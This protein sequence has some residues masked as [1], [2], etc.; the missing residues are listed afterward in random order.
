MRHFG[1]LVAISRRSTHPALGLGLF[2][3]A[4]ALSSALGQTAAPYVLPYTM[5]TYVGAHASYT[6]GQACGAAI[7]LDLDGDGCVAS[8]ASVSTDPHDVRVDPFGFLYYADN[9]NSVGVIHRVNPYSGLFTSYF[10]N[11]IGNSKICATADATT[12]T[13]KSGTGCISSDGV[14][15]SGPVNLL[16]T[17]SGLANG[18]FYAVNTGAIRG[19]GIDP[20]GNLF[21]ANYGQDLIEVIAA[22]GHKVSLVGGQYHTTGTTNGAAYTQNLT[23]FNQPRGVG[24]DAAGNI[25][26]ADTTNNIIRLISGGIIGSTSALIS[27]FTAPNSAKTLSTTPTNVSN[28]LVAAPED[29]QVDLYGNIFIADASNNVVRAVYKAG[30]PLNFFGNLA[31]VVNNVYVVAGS[32]GTPAAGTYAGYPTNGTTPVVSNT[33]VAMGIRKIGLDPL[34]NLYIADSIYNVIWFVDHA[35]AGLRVIAGQYGTTGTAT[36][37]VCGGAT[38]AVGDGCPATQ[39]GIYVGTATSDPATQPDTLGNLYISDSEGNVAAASRIRKVL[40]GLNFPL[41]S[42]TTVGNTATQTVEMHFGVGDSPATTNPY[43]SNNPDFTVPSA[44][45]NLNPVDT[46]TD[47]LLALTFK[48]TVAGYD[49]GTLTVTSLLGATA[50]F[51]VT[52]AGAAPTIAFDP[53]NTSLLA[54]AIKNAQGIVLDGAGNAYIADTGNNQILYYNASTNAT[55]TF[56]AASAGLNGPRAIAL[57][58]D[59]SVYIAD[60]GNNLIR[61]ASPSGAL[62]TIGGGGAACTSATDTF[63]DNCL[64]TQATFSSPSGIAT[65]YL[66]QVFVADTGNNVI[67]QIGT[68][69]YVQLFA[70]G[71]TANCPVSPYP[72]PTPTDSAGDGCAA[73]QATFNKPTAIVFDANS[74]NLFV[75]DT[76]NNVIRKISMTTSFTVAPGNSTSGCANG[77]ATAIAV[78]PVTLVAGNFGAG[79]TLDANYIATNSQLNGPTGIAVGAAGTLYIA[80]TGNQAIRMVTNGVIST[81]AGILSSSGTGTLGTAGATQFQL[82]ADLAVNPYG[83]LFILDSGNNRVLADNRSAVSYNFGTINVNSTSSRQ[84]FTELNLGTTAATLPTPLF[85]ETPTPPNTQLT[86]TA[87]SLNNNSIAACASGTFAAGALCGLQGQFAPTALA[88]D[89]ATFAQSGTGVPAA[90]PAT[91]ISLSGVGLVLEPTTSTI[92]QTVPATGS[93]VFGGPL[94]VQVTVTANTCSPIAPTCNP[95]GNVT[96]IVDGQS[97]APVALTPGSPVSQ[98]FPGL[99][100]GPHTFSC[101]FSS[102]DGFYASGS[103]TQITI[104]VTAAPTTSTLTVTNSGAPQYLSNNCSTNAKTGITTCIVSTLSATVKPTTSAPVPST[105]TVSFY[106]GSVLLGTSSV[107]NSGVATYNLQYSYNPDGSLASDNT[108]PPGSYTLGCTYNGSSNYSTSN[109]TGINYTVIGQ[110]AGITLTPRGCIASSLYPAG[111]STASEGQ[112]CPSPLY[113]LVGTSTACTQT[114]SN[115]AT[116]VPTVATADGSTTDATIFITPTN[117]VSGTFTFACSGMPTYT[118]C[119]FQPTSVTFTPGNTLAPPAYTDVTF[120]TDLQSTSANAAQNKSG[121]AMAT[122]VGWPLAFFGLLGMVVLRRRSGRTALRKLSLLPMLLLLIGSALSLSSCAGP[123]DYKANLTPAGTYPITITVSNGTLKSSTVIDFTVTAPG[124]PGQQ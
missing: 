23:L 7:A 99:S 27:N 119:T 67:R 36:P 5:S 31:P 110:T 57:G 45:C 80:D 69:G 90:A 82:P 3:L 56:V 40:S 74:A 44:P 50:S 8:L 111:T 37:T 48:P 38:D 34:G 116:C 106:N 61:K 9:G 33:A 89:S 96:F 2:L 114:A 73:L 18:P 43:V 63:G 105:G 85:T 24:T 66:G 115:A 6:V 39:A 87:A 25:Y 77:C 41:A 35:T 92:V 30:Y 91:S 124:I 97:Q 15:N 79:A 58:V 12:T 19:L 54:P 95:G 117:T 52:G 28:A 60:T 76:G 16:T 11:E 93:P 107:N 88:T 112:S 109:C 49:T 108:L 22:V 47:C 20:A 64:A 71:A 100:V 84:N 65:D 32:G 102:T 26:V 94:T 10:G 4:G 21:L 104:T 120:F 101:I 72:A 53:G 59:G 13:S 1:R 118:N 70:G 122:I 51:R 81:I 42:P 113:T 86:L 103:C 46:T 29:T 83:K 14:A 55:T 121:I 17:S 75:A 68:S 123:G 62:T 78:N 98:S